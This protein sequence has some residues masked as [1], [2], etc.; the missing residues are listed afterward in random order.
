[1]LYIWRARLWAAT[2]VSVLFMFLALRGIDFAEVKDTLAQTNYALALIALGTVIA[3]TMAKTA[4]WRVLFYPEST[5]LRYHKLLSIMF[6]GQMINFVLPG[7]LGELGRA[8]LVGEV[9]GES[10]I[11]ALGTITIEKTLNLAMLCLSFA[12]LLP[13]IVIP[14]WLEHPGMVSALTTLLALTVFVVIAVKRDRL[15]RLVNRSV[16]KLPEW[17]Q[18]RTSNYIRLAL[19]SL[20]A[21]RHRAAIWRLCGWSVVVW[22]L[23]V[24]T[25]YVTFLAI[26]LPLSFTAAVF[27][28]LVLQLGSAVPALPGRTPMFYLSVLALSLFAIGKDQALSFAALLYVLVYAPPVLL[29]TLFFLWENVDLYKLRTATAGY[30]VASGELG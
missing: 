25:N 19:S 11:R 7:R 30:K 18:A 1:M 10:K 15:Y 23:A 6:I 13:G 24:L 2:G 29:G 8:Y 12:V 20:D 4:R 3:T 16:S 21:L 27:L 9:E 17:G 22:L 5:N 26:G 28:L 14:Q